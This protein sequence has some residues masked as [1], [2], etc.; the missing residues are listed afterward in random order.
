MCAGAWMGLGSG[1]D[2]RSGEMRALAFAIALL[3]V[4]PAWGQEQDLRPKRAGTDQG[5][6]AVVDPTKNVL[7]LVEAA[8]RRQDDL[9]RIEGE[10]LQIQIAGAEKTTILRDDHAKEMAALRADY[11]GQLRQAEAK[12]IDAIRAVDVNAVAV[13]T[14]RAAEQAATLAAN[15]ATSAE[16][17]RALVATTASTQ[18]AS[19]QQVVN[20]LSARLTTL[21]QAGY[22]ATG[23]Q[24]LSDPAFQSLL[25]EVRALSASRSQEA[26][27]DQGSSAVWAGIGAGGGLL[28][29]LIGAFAAFN[30]R[31][32]HTS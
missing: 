12:R 18:A 13:A 24:A 10:K 21:E 15:V 32:A 8:I 22:T 14:Q 25:Q 1:S 7:D 26:G 4:W 28:L 30:S 3:L 19:Q 29:G 20:A 16:A 23:K 31:R 11:D 27:K 6:G 17:L 9:R 2:G 5:V